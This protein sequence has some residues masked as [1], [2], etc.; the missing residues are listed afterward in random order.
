METAKREFRVHLLKYLPKEGLR[1]PL[2]RTEY[3]QILA[4]LALK[5]LEIF[6]CV[7]LGTDTPHRLYKESI[8]FGHFTKIY[9]T[10]PELGE[11]FL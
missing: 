9:A 11:D 6:T 10:L 8:K 7:Y 3:T 1:V 4:A 5:M 2:S